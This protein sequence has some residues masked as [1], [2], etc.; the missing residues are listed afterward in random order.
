MAQQRVVRAIGLDVHGVLVERRVVEPSLKD[1]PAGIVRQGQRNGFECYLRAIREVVGVIP[2][3]VRDCTIGDDVGGAAQELWEV[4]QRAFETVR[5]EES[6]KG[7]EEAP[8]GHRKFLIQTNAVTLR[9]AFPQLAQQITDDAKL[10]RIARAVRRH[11]RQSHLAISPFIAM[12]DVQGFIQWLRENFGVPVYLVTGLERETLRLLLVACG[13][14]GDWRGKVSF[15]AN[16]IGAN[17]LSRRFW[18]GVLRRLG[19]PPHEFLVIGNEVPIDATCTLVGIPALIFDRG[20][21]REE[22]YFGHDRLPKKRYGVPF[23]GRSAEDVPPRAPFIGFAKS[24]EELRQWF[25]LFTRPVS[26]PVGREGSGSG[27]PKRSSH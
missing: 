22:Y 7:E 1:D 6:K 27:G 11:R 18:D 14:D 17:K 21:I 4:E 10:Q 2:L 12:P 5:V 9:N 8:L 19:V 25:N 13:I 20:G 16:E 23:V 24:T 3:A 26:D 15:C